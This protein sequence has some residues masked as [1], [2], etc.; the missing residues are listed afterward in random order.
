[1]MVLTVVLAHYGDLLGA[2]GSIKH[3]SV[4]IE[5]TEE[6]VKQIGPVGNPKQAIWQ[7]EN[8]FIEPEEA[9]E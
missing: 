4:Q 9:N 8:C 1:M 6:Q 5:L 7:I 3:K 2:G